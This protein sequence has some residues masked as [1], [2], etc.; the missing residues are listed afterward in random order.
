MAEHNADTIVR[1]AREIY[2]GW[3]HK[4]A[5]NYAIMKLIDDYEQDKDKFHEDW[6]NVFGE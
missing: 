4:D 6:E 1:L 5:A 2:N 3:D